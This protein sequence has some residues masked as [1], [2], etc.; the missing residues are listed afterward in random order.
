MMTSSF[1]YAPIYTFKSSSPEVELV[2]TALSFNIVILIWPIT[3]SVGGEDNRIRRCQSNS[4]PVRKQIEANT[5]RRCD[6][7]RRWWRYERDEATWRVAGESW[8]HAGHG[9]RDVPGRDHHGDTAAPTLAH[10]AAHGAAPR[11]SG[12]SSLRRL[13]TPLATL[14]H[15]HLASRPP[16]DHRASSHRHHRRQQ[17]ALKVLERMVHLQRLTRSLH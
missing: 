14:R 15:R 7:R 10:P 12:A 9:A 16:R 6:E 13:V 5:R 4:P 11:L 2:K 17:G 8:Q 3:I 1:R